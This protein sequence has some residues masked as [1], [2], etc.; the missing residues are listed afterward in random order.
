M[1]TLFRITTAAILSL[2]ANAAHAYG[3]DQSSHHCEKP[4][5][6]EFQP[7][8]NKYLQSFSEFSLVASANTAPTS[9]VINVSAGETKYH[10]TSKELQITPQKSGRLEIK[11]KMD[12]PI[13]HGFIRLSVTAHSKPTCEK[14][15]GYLIRIQ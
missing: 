13:E 15:E 12:R 1:T 11:G 8:P 4:M 9:I 6:S 3:S 5:F 7:A 10:F 2:S 14:T